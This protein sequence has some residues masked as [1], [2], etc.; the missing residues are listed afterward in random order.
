MS[1]TGYTITWP[2]GVRWEKKDGVSGAPDTKN[3]QGIYI[4][5]FRNIKASNEW[6]G[7]WEL[8]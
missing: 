4:C 7:S 1:N 2:S 6:L 5:K 3:Q 8:W